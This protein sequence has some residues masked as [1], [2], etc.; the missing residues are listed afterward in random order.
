MAVRVFGCNHIVIEVDDIEKAIQ[1][2][3]DVF[4]LELQDGGE[5]DAF[6]K[7]G[8]HQFLAAFEV[9]TLQPDRHKHFGLIVRDEDQIAEVREKITKKY[10]LKTIPPFRCDFHDPW[11][12]RIQ[13]A[14][15]HDE[16]TAWL[17]PYEEVQEVGATLPD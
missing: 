4:D 2:Y 11:G 8:N 12:N 1:F 15:M 17:Q 5:G 7:L 16:S 9:D 14:D 6:F 10:G 3:T 13:V